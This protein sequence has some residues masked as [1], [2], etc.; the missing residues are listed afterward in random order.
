MFHLVDTVLSHFKSI[1][2]LGFI[3]FVYF[4][5]LFFLRNWVIHPVVESHNL[6]LADE[7]TWYHLTYSSIPHNF[8]NWY[9]HK[10]AWLD[11][12]S[13]FLKDTS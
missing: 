7:S 3:L 12:G 9:L 1:T 4:I 6:D 10:K 13:I 8:V 11:S 5:F 2:T